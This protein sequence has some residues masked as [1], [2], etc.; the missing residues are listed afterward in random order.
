[1]HAKSLNIK[2]N[3]KA[4]FNGCFFS[5]VLSFFKVKFRISHLKIRFITKLNPCL[6]T[7]TGSIS[8]DIFLMLNPD[9]SLSRGL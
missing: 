8:K 1:M 3:K 5:V 2:D 6:I 4:A 7:Y 9:L